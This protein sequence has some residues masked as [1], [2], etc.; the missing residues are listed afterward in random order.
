LG[1]ATREFSGRSRGMHQRGLWVCVTLGILLCQDVAGVEPEKEG[2]EGAQ[3]LRVTEW[4][5][6]VERKFASAYEARVVVPFR[7]H[8]EKMRKEYQESLKAGLADLVARGNKQDAVSVQEE[9][10]RLEQQPGF[11]PGTDSEQSSLYLRTLRQQFLLGLGEAEKERDAA[12]RQVHAEFDAALVEG[13]R[14]LAL[15][16]MGS[17]AALVRQRRLDMARIWLPRMRDLFPD[18]HPH[19][20]NESVEGKVSAQSR[21]MSREMGQYTR[22]EVEAAMEWVLGVHGKLTIRQGSRTSL[23]K[24]IS[25][26]PGRRFQIVQV[27]LDGNLMG[28]PLVPGEIRILAALSGVETLKLY[29]LK[30]EEADLEFLKDWRDLEV[31]ELRE[32]SVSSTLARYLAKNVHLKKLWLLDTEGVTLEFFRELALGVQGLRHLLLQ[33][34]PIEDG[35][36]EGIEKQP[37]LEA[38]FLY[39]HGL[40]PLSLPRLANLRGLKELGLSDSVWKPDGARDLEVLSRLKL[41]QFGPLNTGSEDFESRL[42]AVRNAFPQLKRLVLEGERLTVEHAEA[43]RK[44]M[45]SI[46]GIDF[47]GVLPVPGVAAVFAKMPKLDRL[48]CRHPK[49]GDDLAIEFL[50]MRN[51]RVLDLATTG[52]SDVSM[53]AIQKAAEGGLK[54][55]NV[56]HSKLTSAGVQELKHRVPG[57]NLVYQLRDER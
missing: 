45:R 10:Q 21:E 9:L 44:H 13:G 26:L 55:L 38:L 57:L 7:E 31:L 48:H 40:T 30:V 54:E 46:S 37:K 4:L 18:V 5:E 11:P 34:S 56:E 32:M 14:Q 27:W 1:V 2:R 41:E 36:V 49:V 22:K 15:R 8:V 52:I 39:N 42:V 50:G 47:A 23:L 29:N 51:L 33:S 12:V 43:I 3:E 20:G 35:I 6:T 28:R 24:N 25:E 17:E 19:G 16:Q 53:S